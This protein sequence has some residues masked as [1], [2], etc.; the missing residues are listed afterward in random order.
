MRRFFVLFCFALPACEISCDEQCKAAKWRTEAQ[1]QKAEFIASQPEPRDYSFL[2]RE[3]VGITLAEYEKLEMGMT[4]DQAFEVIGTHGR[5]LSE[6]A[7]AGHH[8]VMMSW[9][10]E[11]GDGSN[12][13]AMFQNG[14]MVSKAQFGL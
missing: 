14:R 5:K 12:A 10:G 4:Y 6:S 2:T 8:T 1:Q 11:K 13:N 7:I 9:D 3:R